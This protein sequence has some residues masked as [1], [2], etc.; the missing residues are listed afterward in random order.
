MAVRG[1]VRGRGVVVV[2]GGGGDVRFNHGYSW[3][4]A[5]R[6]SGRAWGWLSGSDSR[7]RVELVGLGCV[8]LNRIQKK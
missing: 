7:L 6:A 3:S 2:G 5:S 8:M 1:V 4:N